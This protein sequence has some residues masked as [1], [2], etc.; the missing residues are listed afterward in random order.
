M[1]LATWLPAMALLGLAVMGLLFL[2]VQACDK[3]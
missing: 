3:I 2:F 1:D